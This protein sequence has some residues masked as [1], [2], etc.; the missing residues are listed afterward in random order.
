MADDFNA[1]LFGHSVEIYGKTE[2]TMHLDGKPT[3]T[4]GRLTIDEIALVG[5]IPTLIGNSLS[6]GASCE[7]S[8]FVVSFPTNSNP[9]ID[10]PIEG[11]DCA[12]VTRKVQD[13]V[14]TFSIAPS[15][16]RVGKAWVWTPSAGLTEGPSVEILT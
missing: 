8:P 1:I 7:V 4:D 10:G 2:E 15:A 12:L 3:I 9:R 14:I 13:T 16:G 6:G 11:T 5:R